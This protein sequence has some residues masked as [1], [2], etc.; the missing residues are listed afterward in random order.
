MLPHE[1]EFF[2]TAGKGYSQRDCPRCDGTGKISVCSECGGL[3]KVAEYHY[4]NLDQVCG[5]SS[6]P[7]P[8]G[9]PEPVQR[10]YS[11]S[12]THVGE[13]RSAGR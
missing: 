11:G 10:F 4:N 3:G 5:I 13:I 12:E 1:R 9:C 8:N 2:Q 6:K 7:C